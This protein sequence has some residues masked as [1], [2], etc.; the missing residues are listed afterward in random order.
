MAPSWHPK[1]PQWRTSPRAVLSL[2]PQQAD[3]GPDSTG[4]TGSTLAPQNLM[5]HACSPPAPQNLEVS[6]SCTPEAPPSPKTLQEVPKSPRSNLGPFAYTARAGGGFST[7]RG[8]PLEL[9]GAQN[10]WGAALAHGGLSMGGCTPGMQDRGVQHGEDAPLELGRGS[11][12][13]GCS[14]AWGAA[15]QGLS[16]PRL[17]RDVCECFSAA[18][19][20]EPVKQDIKGQ[21]RRGSPGP[22]PAPPAPA[23]QKGPQGRQSPQRAGEPRGAPAGDT[24]PGEGA[25]PEWGVLGSEG[26][27]SP[28]RQC[29]SAKGHAMGPGRGQQDKATPAACPQAPTG[30][31]NV[32]GV[33]GARRAG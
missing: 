3:P 7:I 31:G 28:S 15:R 8:A 18:E 20:S 10:T 21:A 1:V 24:Q 12:Q 9:G 17:L 23:P 22:P 2:S 14:R 13:S 16:A 19:P 26:W 27:G 5:E 29:H 30:T 32:R 33:T 6:A 4:D 11:A 25:P